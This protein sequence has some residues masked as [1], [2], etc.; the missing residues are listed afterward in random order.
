MH[1]QTI[2]LVLTYDM[3]KIPPLPRIPT[4]QVF[5]KR[6]LWVYNCGVHTGSKDKGYCY[7]WLEGEAG[8]GAQEV[9]ST[10]K[11]HI[12]TQLGD[13]VQELIL[14][15]DSCGGLNRNIKLAL[16]MKYILNNHPTLKQITLRFLISDHSFLPNDS[17][18]GDIECALKLQQRLY[19]PKGLHTNNGNLPQEKQTNCYT[20]ATWR[21]SWNIICR[22]KHCKKEERC[23]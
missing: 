19:A 1:Q 2:N 3:E 9:G 4:N 17:D 12:H 11:K 10:L 22:K 5:Y 8:R 6:Q 14:W 23:A 13:K 7:V 16:M 15:S 21:F 20:D 18:F